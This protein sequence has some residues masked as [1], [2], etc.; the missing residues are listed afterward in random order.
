[1]TKNIIAKLSLTGLLAITPAFAQNLATATIPFDFTVGQTKMTAGAYTVRS[2][3]PGAIQVVR[4]DSKASVFVITNGVQASQA[5][6]GTSLVFNR[7]GDS[8]FLAQLW[9]A[10][11]QLG[12]Q[13][14]KSKP[15]MEVARAAGSVRQASVTANPNNTL[16]SSR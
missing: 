3:V 15:E 16:T 5:P 14:P 8:Y 9:I 6:K 7:Y 13:L 10:G 1:M 2:I 11:N 12:K 4:D